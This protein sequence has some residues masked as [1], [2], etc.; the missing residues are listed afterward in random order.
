MKVA[1]CL[2]GGGIKGAAHIGALK[3]FEENG[4]E[5]EY[6]SGTS[7][8]SIVATL[9]AV[10]YK[11]D[12]IYNIFKKYAK[13][14]NY[15][16]IGAITNILKNL[17]TKRKFIV[18]GFNSGKLIEKA[19][20]EACEEKQISNMEQIKK[21]LLIPSV[22]LENGKVYFFSSMQKRETFSNDI[23]YVNQINIGKAVRA[24]CSYP[25]AFCPCEYNGRKLI[26][27][28]IRENVPWK[29]WK[30][31]GVDKVIC[32]GFET[33]KKDKK[34]KNII[35]IISNALDILCYEL[36]NY[37]LIGADYLLEIKTKDVSLLDIK[38]MD[39]LYNMGYKQTKNF[40]NT[41]L[42]ENL[43]KNIFNKI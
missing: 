5:F 11:A 21:K 35:D 17:V 43:E 6:I 10:G 1:L 39:Y 15:V 23:I 12:E 8:G 19:I 33:N 40:I 36:S 16:D 32:I 27:G 41:V 24:S 14:M 38:E 42:K 22:D 31:N 25:G 30:K 2:A 9:N 18:E 4:M 13:K 7:S 34:D 28:G 20:N 29:E 37:E 3:A 26:D